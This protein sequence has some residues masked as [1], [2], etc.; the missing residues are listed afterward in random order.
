MLEPL[1]RRRGRP[2]EALAAVIVDSWYAGQGSIEACNVTNTSEQQLIFWRACRKHVGLICPH[3][4]RQRWAEGWRCDYCGGAAASMHEGMVRADLRALGLASMEQVKV[5]RGAYGAVDFY[6]PAYD[7]IIQVDGPGHVEEGCKSVSL[8]AQQEI[9][10]RFNAEA[11]RQGRRLLRL[12][13]KDVEFGYTCNYVRMAVGYCLML[14]HMGFA[15]FSMR[16]LRAGARPDFFHARRPA[17][18]TAL[19]AQ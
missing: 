6:V 14:P 11:R 12:H 13:F 4:L 3:M 15:F 9:D 19:F 7:L 16:H 8:E 2:P 5:L 1:R 17:P 18:P 10:G